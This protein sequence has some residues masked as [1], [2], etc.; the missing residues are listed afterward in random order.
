MPSLPEIVG[1][2]EESNSNKGKHCQSHLSSGSYKARLSWW[3]SGKES[4][5]N[6]ATVLIPGLGRS[7][8]EEMATQ[9]SILA[10][11]SSWTEVPGGLQSIGLQSQTVLSTH[12]H[13]HTQYEVNSLA[14]F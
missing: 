10:E 5:C 9:S 6:G 14:E 2:N 12:T 3:L 13:T 8:K 11:K 7:L 4:A 1:Y